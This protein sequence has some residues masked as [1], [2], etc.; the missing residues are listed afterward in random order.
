MPMLTG[1]PDEWWVDPDQIP[2]PV[3]TFGVDMDLHGE[4]ELEPHIHAKGQILLALRGVISCEVDG[5]LW[6]VPP[7]S[8]IWI[9]GGET[10]AI[11]IAGKSQGYGAFIDP[12]HAARLPARCCAIQATALLREL[13]ARAARM[14]MLYPHGGLEEHLVTLLL[15]EVAA[16]PIG[17]L[18][19]PLP[20]DSRL[21][22]IVSDMLAEPAAGG[23]LASWA[24]RA[25]MSE[26]T[27]A[28]RLSRETGMSF[29]RWRQRINVMLALQWLAD[30]QSIQQVSAALGYESASSFVTQFRK[31]LGVPPGRYMTERRAFN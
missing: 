17:E 1:H 22:Q 30:G 20:A 5:G 21:R 31:V 13:L 12:A 27:F 10:H 18:H 4:F 29:S 11:R 25:G 23:T 7:Q 24:K 3:L 9:P 19:L 14:P 16:A 28:R 15:D 6:I 26:R 2:R 8:A